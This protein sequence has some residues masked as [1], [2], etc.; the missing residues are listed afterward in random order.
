MA[1]EKIEVAVVTTE[2]VP[3]SKI[4]GLA[5]VMG[6]LPDEL[7]KLGTGITVFTP[8]YASIDRA[9]HGIKRVE[10]IGGLSVKVAGRDH[11]FDL[12]V[13]IKPGAKRLN[14]QM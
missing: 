14:S 6:A 3:Y 1:S 5:D 10:E 9:K 12:A 11:P 7:E 13:G 2:I 8:L 4:G